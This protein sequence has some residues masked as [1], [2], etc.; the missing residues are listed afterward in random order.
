M[1]QATRLNGLIYEGA[2]RPVALGPSLGIRQVFPPPLQVYR[3]SECEGL[4]VPDPN[5]DQAAIANE[6]LVWF[7]RLRF[8][9]VPEVGCLN[10]RLGTL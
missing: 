10:D 3:L 8:D 7:S 9:D 6:R 5:G 2:R 1:I 4:Y